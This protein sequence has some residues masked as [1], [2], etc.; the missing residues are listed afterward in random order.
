MS[1][2]TNEKEKVFIYTNGSRSYQE[3]QLSEIRDYLS[4]H[5]YEVIESFIDEKEKIENFND[6]LSRLNEVD[7]LIVYDWHE[8]VSDDF[9]SALMLKKIERLKKFIIVVIFDIKFS[10]DTL[11]LRLVSNVSLSTNLTLYDGFKKGL[12]KYYE[13]ILLEWITLNKKVIKK[14]MILFSGRYYNEYGVEINDLT[15]KIKNCSD[16]EGK[17]RL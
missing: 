1:I 6:L 7:G 10:Y 2:K 17:N 11:E 4:I 5:K 15:H 8:I 12:K 3:F 16:Y 9:V 14:E 13:N